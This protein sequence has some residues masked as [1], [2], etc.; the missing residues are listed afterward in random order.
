[1]STPS[2][3]PKFGRTWS[4]DIVSADGQTSYNISN[5]T[6]DP[7]ALRIEFDLQQMLGQALWQGEISIWNLD[8]NNNQQVQDLTQGS[9]VSLSA[10]Y[11]SDGNP[12][13]VWKG[14]VYQAYWWKPDSLNNILTM[15]FLVG[16]NTKRNTVSRT[17]APGTSQT[18]MVN[19]IAQRAGI[20][21]AYV[22]PSLQDAPTSPRSTVVFGDAQEFLSSI[23]KTNGMEICV[24]GEGKFYMGG[25][26]RGSDLTPDLIY[27]SPL[28]PGQ[29]GIQ[30]QQEVDYTLLGSPQQTQSGV[31][32]R[33]LLDSRLKVQ[34]PPIMVKLDNTVIRQLAIQYGQQPPYPLASDD[35]YLVAGVRH[36]GDS[37]GNTWETEVIA[38]N[39]HRSILPGQIGN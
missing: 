2:I 17:F 38:A 26:T 24:D 35:L 22:D 20:V 13:Q 30:E 32:F 36:R 1:M 39:A 11:Q 5:S 27:S 19:D 28:A 29:T 34:L 23:A 15:R 4:L 9:I 10:G 21:I 16:T 18:A 37:R 6:N 25:F 7:A 33:V 14:E 8:W 31:A 3:I 12:G